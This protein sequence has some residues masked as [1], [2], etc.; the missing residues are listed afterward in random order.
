MKAYVNYYDGDGKRAR[1]TIGDDS[2]RDDQCVVQFSVSPDHWKLHYGEAQ[3]VCGELNHAQIH[4][5]KWP[6]HECHFEVEQVGEFEC[7]IV[8]PDHPAF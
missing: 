2:I 6:G 1:E 8:C 5:A 3:V 7:V 4:S